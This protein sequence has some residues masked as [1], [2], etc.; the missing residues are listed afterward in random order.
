MAYLLQSDCFDFENDTS[1]AR[2]HILVRNAHLLIKD[3]LS[4]E[5]YFGGR[6]QN[7]PAN[8]RRQTRRQTRTLAASLPFCIALHADLVS[9]LGLAS[10]LMLLKRC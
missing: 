4:P 6:R 3:A 8:A 2:Q 1:F 5:I 10:L 7:A 9:R